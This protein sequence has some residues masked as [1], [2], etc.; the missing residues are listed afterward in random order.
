MILLDSQ[1]KKATSDQVA[2]FMSAEMFSDTY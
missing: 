1:I 2:F